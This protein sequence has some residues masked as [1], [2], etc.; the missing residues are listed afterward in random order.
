MFCQIWLIYRV[1]VVW[2]V[3]ALNLLTAAIA[4]GFSLSVRLALYGSTLCSLSLSAMS[5]NVKQP[6]RLF[7][8]SLQIWL[9][10]FNEYIRNLKSQPHKQHAVRG[11]KLPV[12]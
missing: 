10:A 11:L 12:V 5:A 9:V 3:A 8:L 6:G 7:L 1:I 4:P 2:C